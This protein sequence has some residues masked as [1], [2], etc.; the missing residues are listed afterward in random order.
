[1]NHETAEAH[2]D[3]IHGILKRENETGMVDMETVHYLFVQAMIHGAK[4][5]KAESTPVF[6][7]RQREIQ[8]M[9]D[10][11]LK[12]REI[13]SR[14]GISRRTVEKHRSNIGRKRKGVQDA[15]RP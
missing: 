11:K 8:G 12:S 5:E 4:H 6:T 3:F 2:W 14:L 7:R 13:A 10:Q 9:V 15:A 1:M